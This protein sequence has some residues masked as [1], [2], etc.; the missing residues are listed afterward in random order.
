MKAIKMEGVVNQTTTLVPKY[1]KL[2]IS[3]HTTSASSVAEPAPP[4]LP[5]AAGARARGRGWRVR[6]RQQCDRPELQL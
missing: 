1:Q 2:T 4:R 5:R 3:G 6:E